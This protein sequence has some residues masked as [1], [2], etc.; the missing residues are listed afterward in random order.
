MFT[1]FRKLMLE[2][3]I[4][5]KY[6]KVREMKDGNTGRQKKCHRKKRKKVHVRERDKERRVNLISQK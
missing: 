3:W 1:F 5:E 2:R 6:R 4:L